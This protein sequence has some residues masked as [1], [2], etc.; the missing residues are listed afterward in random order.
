M[1]V[2]WRIFIVAWG[3]RKLATKFDMLPNWYHPDKSGGL[4]PIGT[5]SVWIASILAVPAIYLGTWQILCAGQGIE[6][7]SHILRIESRMLYFKELLLVV[8]VIFLISFVWPLWTTHQVMVRKREKVQHYELMMVEQKIN[9]ISQQIIENADKICQRDHDGQKAL[10]E[11]MMLQKKLDALQ[12][13]YLDLQHLPVWPFNKATIL[14]LISTQ[15]IPLLGLTGTG[16]KTIDL[17]K[18]LFK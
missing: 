15:G 12:K 9:K 17:L 16:S 11:N 13:T 7:C 18:I 3:I 5:T 10:D 6:V 14:Q 4:L 8:F 2:V 1:L